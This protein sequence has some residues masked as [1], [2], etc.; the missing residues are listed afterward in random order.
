MPYVN[1]KIA[2]TLEPEQ[3]EALARRFTEALEE[4]ASK[5]PRYTY[6][7]IEEVERENWAIA[8]KLLS[9]PASD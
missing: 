6:V 7:V 9:G 3:K 8:G 2:G 4:I 1:L 5:P